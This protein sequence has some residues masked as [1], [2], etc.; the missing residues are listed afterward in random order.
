MSTGDSEFCLT[1]AP[2]NR[3][4][5]W[6]SCLWRWSRISGNM[7]H[8]LLNVVAPSLLS[9]WNLLLLSFR[10]FATRL[11]PTASSAPLVICHSV[12][13]SCLPR[14]LELANKTLLLLLTADYSCRHWLFYI[15]IVFMCCRWR[16]YLARCYA[17]AWSSSCSQTVTLTATRL[18][19]YVVI[20]VYRSTTACLYGRYNSLSLKTAFVKCSDGEP[21]LYFL[22]GTLTRPSNIKGNT[23]DTPTLQVYCG[24]ARN[25]HW[26]VCSPGV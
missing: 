22:N 4:A 15:L 18:F 17:R 9:M 5:G 23:R 11:Y 16:L 14:L 10:N 3:T 21:C 1:V 26:S 25:F 24:D 7:D 2:V 19:L 6:P 12:C 8:T 20:N 13:S